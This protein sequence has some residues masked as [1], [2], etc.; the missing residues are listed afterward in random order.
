MG[1]RCIITTQ[2][3]WCADGSGL[4]LHWNGGRDSVNAFTTYCRLKGF[5]SPVR[6]WGYA[7]A[8]LTQVVSNWFGGSLSVGIVPA[9]CGA[10][11]DNGV[12]FLGND[13]KVARHI[14]GDT[15]RN[16]QGPE[17]LEYDLIEFVHSIN[18]KQPAAEQIDKRILQALLL[19]DIYPTT[20]EEKIALC[21]P[22]T[23]IAVQ[24]DLTNE[25]KV[26]EVL[27]RGEGVVNGHDV[28]G[29]PFY[30]FRHY[31]SKYSDPLPDTEI[32]LIKNNPNSYLYNY[33]RF[34]FY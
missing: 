11:D 2:K 5:R 20:Y 28:T 25:Y 7:L 6:D 29:I 8:R 4:Y 32:D 10:G 13:W 33:T 1:N 27:G 14:D 30:N 3:A 9:R 22:G 34:C 31:G 15:G 23:Q 16:W 26:F 19:E 12:F 18:D 21:T 17:Q 24:D